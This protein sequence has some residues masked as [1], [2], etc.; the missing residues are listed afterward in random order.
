MA[1]AAG[2]RECQCWIFKTITGIPRLGFSHGVKVKW[3]EDGGMERED[4]EK[5]HIPWY[6]VY[7]SHAMLY[8]L[9]THERHY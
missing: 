4:W 5:I 6:V 8:K 9:Q 2:E 7:K 1:R 3:R